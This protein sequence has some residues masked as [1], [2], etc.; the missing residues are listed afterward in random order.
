MTLTPPNIQGTRGAGPFD[1]RSGSFLERLLFNHRLVVVLVCAIVTGL[2]G[3][4]AGK[5]LVDWHAKPVGKTFFLDPL[6]D[7]PVQPAL[8]HCEREG[9]DRVLGSSRVA[10]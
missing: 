10:E 8:D 1:T 9:D 4:Q 2:L 3:Y 6:D 7:P 5:H